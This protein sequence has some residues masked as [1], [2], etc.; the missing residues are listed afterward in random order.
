M[1]ARARKPRP[2]LMPRSKELEASIDRKTPARPA[3]GPAR[4]TLTRRIVMTLMPAV[5]AAD[6]YSPMARVRR[7][8]R[9]L[10][11]AKW[12]PK[13]ATIAMSAKTPCRRRRPPR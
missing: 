13:T 9:V 8:Q 1:I 6:G 5:S 7:P 4:V 11:S 10:N 2:A 3:S 12:M